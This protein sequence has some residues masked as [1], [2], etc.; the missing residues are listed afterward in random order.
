[1]VNI[2]Y[3]YRL[4]SNHFDE[5]AYERDLRNELLGLP[6]RRRL[7]AEAVPTLCLSRDSSVEVTNTKNDI[8]DNNK[9]KENDER[10]VLSLELQKQRQVDAL[11]R[12]ES[13]ERR[14]EE[15]NRIIMMEVSKR[16]NSPVEVRI[17]SE[18][19]K[20]GNYISHKAVLKPKVRVSY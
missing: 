1:M 12:A 15:V 10:D 20:D 14:K 4:F 17:E 6:P 5:T 2:I 11:Q 9:R 16:N 3:I 13:A 7:K 18:T 8:A 19:S